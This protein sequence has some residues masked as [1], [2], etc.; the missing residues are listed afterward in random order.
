MPRTVYLLGFNIYPQNP[1][2]IWGGNLVSEIA[3]HNLVYTNLNFLYDMK[4]KK[5]KQIN[6]S[7]KK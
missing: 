2:L 3:T 1:E 6:V 5:V 4:D 7:R